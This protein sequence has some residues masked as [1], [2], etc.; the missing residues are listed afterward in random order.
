MSFL[1]VFLLAEPPAHA[2]DAPLAGFDAYVNKAI[3]DW[4]VPGVAIAIIKDD[5]IVLAKGYGVREFGKP[6]P[7][8]STRFLPSVRRQRL[9]PPPRWRCWLTKGK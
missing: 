3:Q 4:E 9:S 5:K 6:V 8:P 1:V 2:Q 7:S